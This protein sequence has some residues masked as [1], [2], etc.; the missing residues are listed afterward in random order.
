MDEEYDVVYEEEINMYH[1]DRVMISKIEEKRIRNRVHSGKST[2]IRESNH[3][4]GVCK[5]Y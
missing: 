1:D 2:T 5:E 3:G 4:S